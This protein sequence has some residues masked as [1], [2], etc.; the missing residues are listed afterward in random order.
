M[1]LIQTESEATVCLHPTE[2]KGEDEV[3]DSTEAAVFEQ[4]R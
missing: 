1:Y 2:S 4:F 3:S